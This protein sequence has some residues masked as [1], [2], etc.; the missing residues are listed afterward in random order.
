MCLSLFL[1]CRILIMPYIK[2]SPKKLPLTKQLDLKAQKCGLRHTVFAPNGDQYTGEW[3]DD[4]K[5]GET[6]GR[7]QPS[8]WPRFFFLSDRW[9]TFT[10][11]SWRKRN[12]TVE[13]VRSRVQRRME[14]WPMWRVRYLQRVSTWNKQVRQEVLRKME[15]WEEARKSVCRRWVTWQ[16]P[17]N[18]TVTWRPSLPVP[19]VM[20]RFST[21]TQRSTKETGVRTRGA[22][23]AECTRKRGTFMRESGWGTNATGKALFSLVMKRQ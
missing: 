2:T 22:A 9:I 1:N 7:G 8:L 20:G 16:R 5:H 3:L 13:E 21:G 11:H 10:V 14:M 19:R 23:G 12:S 17:C 6:P 4:R 18:H 15:E